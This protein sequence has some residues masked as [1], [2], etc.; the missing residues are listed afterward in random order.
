ADVFMANDREVIAANMPLM[1]EERALVAGEIRYSVVNKFPLRDER[2]RPY[3]VCGIATT[4]L[5][6]NAQRR[7]CARA[8][9]SNRL[10][11]IR[12]RPPSPCSRGTETSPPSTKIG[13]D[14]REKP[15][16]RQLLTAWASITW[17]SAAALRSRGMAR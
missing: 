7:R 6:A 2:G 5:S 3:A 8:G 16:A 14:S 15:A 13:D 1:F 12:L 11:S 9:R 10:Y 17:T 4:S